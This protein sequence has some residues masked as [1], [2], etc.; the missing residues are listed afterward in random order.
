MVHQSKLDSLTW[1]YWKPRFLTAVSFYFLFPLFLTFWACFD[2]LTLQEQAWA[3]SGFPVS[4]L[5]ELDCSVRVHIT[6]QPAP[7]RAVDCTLMTHSS[8][9]G[10]MCVSART[11]APSRI[12]TRCSERLQLC[13]ANLQTLVLIGPEWKFRFGFEKRLIRGRLG[14][15]SRMAQECL[16]WTG[17]MVTWGRGC[18]AQL[19]THVC[20]GCGAE[21]GCVICQTLNRVLACGQFR[22]FPVCFSIL[23]V[24]VVAA[25]TR[26]RAALRFFCVHNSEILFQSFPHTRKLFFFFFSPRAALCSW[27]CTDHTRKAEVG[28]FEPWNFQDSQFYIRVL[29]ES[30]SA[31]TS[32]FICLFL[33]LALSYSYLLCPLLFN[34]S[35]WNHGSRR[36]FGVTVPLDVG[37][38]KLDVMF[39]L[40]RQCGVEEADSL[41]TCVKSALLQLSCCFN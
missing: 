32:K 17:E 38:N 2:P 37:S 23:A 24:T 9:T 20:K 31:C 7:L 22:S 12:E 6:A 36:S 34:T 27:S 8:I 28:K 15:A 16:R 4:W 1:C 26:C 21:Q 25:Q 18:S 30:F 11:S 14:L 33:S 19:Q 3:I 5:S 29:G 10:G 40:W 35:M 39:G 41:R 13:A